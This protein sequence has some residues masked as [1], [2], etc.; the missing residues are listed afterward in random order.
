MFSTNRSLAEDIPFEIDVRDFKGYE[1][2]EHIAVES[3]DLRAENSFEHPEVIVS[4]A[5]PATV[6]IDGM[7]HT[8][9]HRMS[10]NVFHLGKG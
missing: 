1:L 3:D 7:V 4:H 8:V 2:L 9:L 5:V 6:L 10:W